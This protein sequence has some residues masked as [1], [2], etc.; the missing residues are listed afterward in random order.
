MI[1]ENRRPLLA[2]ALVATLCAGTLAQGVR[3]EALQGIVAAQVSQ[4]VVVGARL[5]PVGEEVVAP[6]PV[7]HEE[8]P[9]A[10]AGNIPAPAAVKDSPGA[11]T[12]AGGRT[13]RRTD[14]ETAQGRR[15]RA[16]RTH[17]RPPDHAQ[18]PGRPDHAGAQRSH[19]E[20]PREPSARPPVHQHK[21]ERK[22]ERKAGRD[23]GGRYHRGHAPAPGKGQGQG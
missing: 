10:P 7:Q 2:F 1:R 23:A 22:A 4:V 9:A 19:R 13:H 11:P 6:V 16:D 21:A 17:P 12:Q 8:P 5:A 18:S 14:G 3:S 20:V 15:G